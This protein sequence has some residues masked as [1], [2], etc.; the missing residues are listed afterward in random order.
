[1]KNTKFFSLYNTDYL[2]VVESTTSGI[3]DIYTIRGE[4]IR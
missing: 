4:Y 1:M 2:S 3:M